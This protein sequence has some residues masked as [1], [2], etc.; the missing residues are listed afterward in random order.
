MRWRLTSP[1]V[2]YDLVMSGLSVTP[3]R[4]IDMRFSDAYTKATVSFVVRDHLRSKFSSREA[5]K[6]LVTPRIGVVDV[7]GYYIDKLLGISPPS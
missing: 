7:P 2:R 1:L 5:V 6:G 3:D 4:M